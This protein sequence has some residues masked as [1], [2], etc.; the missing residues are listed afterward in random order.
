MDPQFQGM[1][2]EGCY[3]PWSP[4]NLSSWTA[5]VHSRFVPNSLDVAEAGE[6]GTG[7]RRPD[8]RARSYCSVLMR[9]TGVC[10]AFSGGPLQEW[11]EGC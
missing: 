4:V 3:P 10:V 2:L 7:I 11:P 5:L 6:L 9:V 8:C 1:K